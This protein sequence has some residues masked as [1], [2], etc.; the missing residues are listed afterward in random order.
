MTTVAELRVR[1]SM[2]HAYLLLIEGVPFAFTDE[3]ALSTAAGAWWTFDD[4]VILDG[5]VVPETLV[6]SIDVESGQF[7]DDNTTFQLLDFDET[8][9]PQFF[10][11]LSKDFM[12]LGERLTPLQDPAPAFL[13]DTAQGVFAPAG[14]YLGTE[15]IGPEGERNYYSATPWAPSAPGQDHPTFEEP[16]PVFTTGATGPYLVEGR[17]VTLLRIIWD[18]DTGQWPSAFSQ[19]T[20]ALENGWAPAI[21]FGTLRQAGEVDGRLWSIDCAGPG[22]WLR[23]SLATRASTKWYPVTADFALT[24]QEWLIG[25]LC[26]KHL[27]TD[28]SNKVFG[29]DSVSYTVD[30]SDVFGSIQTAVYAIAG[31]LGIDGVWTDTNT[32]G[33]GEIVFEPDHVSV[34]VEAGNGFNAT[35]FLTLHLKVWRFLGYDPIAEVGNLDGPGPKFR[36]SIYLPGYY[37]AVFS[38]TPETLDPEQTDLTLEWAGADAPRIYYPTYAGGLSIIT[39]AGGQVLRLE[40]EDSEPIYVEA[41]TIRP[42]VGGDVDG[43][44]CTASR[45]WA[46]RGPIQLEGGEVEDTVQ[47]ARCSWVEDF[48]G[49]MATDLYG[50]DRGL[51]VHEWLD[52]RLFGLNYRPIAEALGW[53]VRNEA[54]AEDDLRVKASPLSVFGILNRSPDRAAETILRVLLSTGTAEWDPAALDGTDAELPALWTSDLTNGANGPYDREI[55]DLGLALPLS[56]VDVDSFLTAAQELPGGEDGRLAVGKVA[57]H[58]TIQSEQL[59]EALMAGRA[60]T[61]SLIRGRFGIYSPHIGAEEKFDGATDATLTVDDL[62]GEAGDPAST[63]PTVQLRP[64]FP[65]E[66]LVV[67]YAGDP[68]EGWADGQLELAC[69]ARDL[70]ARARRG[71]EHTLTCPDL[72]ATEWLVGDPD[73]QVDGTLGS[74]QTEFKA[75]WERTIPAWLARPHRLIQGLRISRTQGQDLGVGSLVRLSNPWP[76]NSYGTYGLSGVAGRVVSVTH[77]TASCAAVVDILAEA[78]PPD[79]QRWAPVL[80][81]VDAGVT[82]SDARW[83]VATQTWAFRTWGGVDPALPL[84]SLIRPSDLGL[85]GT[86][87]DDVRL[88]LLAFD[89]VTW[90]RIATLVVAGVNLIARTL[91]M[92][93]A[94]LDWEGGYTAS[95]WPSRAY[96]V[97]VLDPAQDC[98]TRRRFARHTPVGGAGARKLAK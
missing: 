44:A 57:V 42:S 19:W 60:W 97:M 84:A 4:R 48:P 87:E 29:N 46:F 52:P 75:L 30:P 56:M 51:Y 79:L 47:V 92:V 93:D 53:A 54:D 70:G 2:R 69:K 50:I 41:Q 82:D 66:R 27:F 28:T 45:W 72:I 5:L 90:E 89:G 68:V 62:A 67:S 36:T 64:V 55:A 11:N 13:Q 37:T 33:A 43:V 24:N 7:Q 3:H 61:W 39:G 8:T 32:E 95:K 18:E 85:E 59:L 63:I 77:E 96:L 58:G 74:W 17:R 78:T 81:V 71:R 76:A 12:Q 25:I 91:T 65:F 1:P 26:N 6:T 80:R 35:I 15:A 88:V 22:S 31:T 98:W 14:G 86:E 94:D 38:S 73:A 16:N 40:S 34:S 49:F 10:G 21:W 23:K 20:E 9:I 83:N